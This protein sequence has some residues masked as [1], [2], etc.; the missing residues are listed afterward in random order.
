M[1]H[2]LLE[3]DIEYVGAEEMSLKMNLNKYE[4]GI[5]EV[6]T[7]NIRRDWETGMI[8]DYDYALVPIDE[9]EARDEQL[10]QTCSPEHPMP[11]DA[12]GRWEHTNVEEIKCEDG[13]PGGDVVTLRCKDCGKIWR[14]ESP[15]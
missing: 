9:K 8:D 10:R 15:Q 5:Y 13:H 6:K 11:K 3:N 2:N 12:T 1:G 4:D 14:S 7:C